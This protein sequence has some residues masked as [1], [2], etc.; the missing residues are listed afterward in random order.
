MGGILEGIKVLELASVLAG[1]SVGMF[2]AELGATVIKVENPTTSGDTT[3]QWKLPE[4]DPNARVTAYFA[5]VNWGKQYLSIN[6]K[7]EEGKQQVYSLAKDS[8]IIIANYK[9]GD[10]KKLGMDYDTFKAIKPDII[11]GHI[12][13]YGDTDSRAAFDVVL[14]AESGY[15]DSNGKPGTGPQKM[16]VAMV[17]ILA[18]HQMK[19][20]LMTALYHKQRTGQ[21]AYV[22][23]SLLTAS[24]SAL[25]NLACNWLMVGH[26]SQQI[27]NHHSTISPYGDLLTTKD[28]KYTVLAVGTD[29][30]FQQLCLILGVPDLATDPRF[31]NNRQRVINRT[32]LMD[33][34][35][36]QANSMTRD[37]LLHQL[38]E[39]KVPAGA[40][41][42][43]KEV[44]DDPDC[45]GLILEE[46]IECIPTKRP[47]S[48]GF[49]IK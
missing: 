41:R 20:G 47:R 16:P 40:V 9:P 34:L 6:V 27:G 21:G 39:H 15:M 28:G 25:T 24:I 35:Q 17:D 43:M 4:E 38:N 31:A 44:F 13:G 2:F 49:S 19:E 29:K 1:P 3:R 32:E 36:P 8:D 46:T 7:T 23:A 48:V 42:N 5:S 11:Y 18:A 30:Q 26:N 37:E 10:D 45:E 14:Q 33:L 22:T 12:T